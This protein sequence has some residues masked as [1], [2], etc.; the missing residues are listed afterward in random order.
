MATARTD[1]R[2]AVSSKLIQPIDRDWQAAPT[3]P[4]ERPSPDRLD[5]LAWIPVDVPGTAASARRRAGTEPGRPDAEDWWFRTTFQAAAVEPSEEVLLCLGGLATIAE[6]YLNGA[7]LLNSESMFDRHSIDVGSRLRGRNELAIVFRALEPRLATQRRPRARWR[8]RLVADNNLRWFRTTLLGRIPGF[9]PGPAP[10]GP[11]RPIWLERRRA[12]VADGVAVR[13]GLDGTTGVLRVEARLRRVD[14]QPIT[15]AA[16]ELDG[17]S[18]RWRGELVV[19]Q[20][21]AGRVAGEVRIPDVARW[22]PHTHG[23]AALHAVVLHVEAS[24][25]THTIGAGR[26]GFRALQAGPTPGHDVDRDG[27]FVHVNGVPVFARGALWTPLD[28]VS[29]GATAADLRTALEAARDA[30]MNMLRLPGFGTYEQDA[31]HDLCDELGILVWQDLMFASMDYPFADH[32]FGR[33]ASAEVGAVAARLAGR[34][35]T[36]VVCGGSEVQQQVAMLGLDLDLVHIPFYEEVVP[37]LLRDAG[38]DAIY[39]PSAPSGGDLPLRPNRGVSNY[40]AVGGYRAPLSDARTSGVRFASECLAFANVP[41]EEALSG[42]VPEPPGDAFMHHPRWKAGVPRDSGSGWDFDDLRDDY[43]AMLFGVEPR[44]LR[45]G[46]H[47]R[48]V[49][50]SRA[51]SGEV[52]ASVFGEWRRAESPSGGGM[53]LWLRDL[54]A[55]AGW[56]V[57]D[58][59]GR[60]KTAYHHLRRSL[61]PTAVWLV[62]E[63][64]SGVVAHL[65]NDGPSALRARLRIALYTDFELPVGDAALPI[66]LPAH[67]SVAHDVELALGRFVDAAWAYRFGPPAQDAIV[68]TLERDGPDGVEVLSQA[69]HFPAGRPLTLEPASRLGLS[70][71]AVSGADGRITLTVVSRRL[72]YGVRIHAPGFAPSDD[73]FSVEPSGSRIIRLVPD[74]PERHFAGGWLTA[75]NLSGQVAVPI[76]DETP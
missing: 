74:I 37:G 47:D 42:L 64:I 76:G 56:G 34:P 62:D 29:L 65:A 57:I 73:A 68:A 2:P 21:E 38:S 17:P 54:V 51:V 59:R 7:L 63:G 27:L 71:R 48:Y 50:L 49:E 55:G 26:V 12:I 75:L 35:S 22:W 1:A 39:V 13:T 6:V 11:W 32:A 72:A 45:R 44:T 4:D 14:G 52:M 5:D 43:L 24:G 46:N 36:T 30:G 31:F 16:V 70:A 9:A 61:A 18:G 15:A 19:D 40:Y 20:D 8:T 66:D 58:N 3:T 67:G 33:T 60:P 53:I 10:V 41:D 23:E 69:F 28:V 25:E